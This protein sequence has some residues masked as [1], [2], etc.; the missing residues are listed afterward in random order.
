MKSDEE[1]SSFTISSI[2]CVL[3]DH[4][5]T[6]GLRPT[7]MY[8]E[9]DERFFPT[10]MRLADRW[11]GK[12]PR[13][14]EGGKK[15]LTYVGEWQSSCDVFK[16]QLTIRLFMPTELT[17]LFFYRRKGFLTRLKS[18]THDSFPPKAAL[19][20]ELEHVKSDILLK[21][22]TDKSLFNLFYYPF[23]LPSCR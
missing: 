1:N 13:I 18:L 6:V 2:C 15:Q 10:I 16:V 12:I 11:N 21:P 4:L 5:H 14:A 20:L 9:S 23:S 17:M 3:S 19:P 8:G 22:K 7:L